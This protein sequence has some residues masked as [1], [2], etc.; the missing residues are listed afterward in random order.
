MANRP[1]RSG[2]AL[3]DG[4]KGPQ[5]SIT[6]KERIAASVPYLLMRGASRDCA[7]EKFPPSIKL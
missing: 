3:R 5:S 4:H 7:H 2:F 6:W 1:P